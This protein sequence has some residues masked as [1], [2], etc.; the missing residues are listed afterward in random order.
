M[1]HTNAS[2]SAPSRTERLER[3]ID[4]LEQLSKDETLNETSETLI[5][6]DAETEQ[7]LIDLYDPG[8]AIGSLQVCNPGR[9]G[10]HCEPPRIG[11][12]RT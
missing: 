4:T 1:P 8:H 9:S 3:Q 7:L 12:A 5:A 6:F 11:P 2:F 10:G